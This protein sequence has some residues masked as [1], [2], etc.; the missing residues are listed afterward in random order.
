M[1]K[2]KYSPLVTLVM[3][4]IKEAI[5]EKKWHILKDFISTWEPVDIV[6]LFKELNP[7]D[8]FIIFLMLPTNLQSAV[9]AKFDAN[10]QEKVLKSLS[11]QQVRQILSEIKPDDRTELFEE[12]PPDMIRK[13]LNI[14]S[15]EDRKEV[16]QLLAYPKDSVGRLLTPDYVA[17]KPSWTISNTMEHIRKYGKDAETVNVVYVV[18]DMG[19]LLDDIPIRK[20]ILAEP[21][22]TVESIMDRSYVSIN[23]YADQEEAAKVMQKYDLI[24]L[25]VT[26]NEGQLL[27]IVTIDD[28]IDVLQEEQTEDFTKL[29]A[30]ATKPIKVDFITKLKEIPLHKLYRSRVTWLLALLLMDLITGGII[31]SFEETIAR[32]VVLVTF[33]PVLVDT[34]G[35]AGSQSATLVIRAMALG[36]IQMADWF[37]LLGRE[38]LVA[39]A[40]GITMGLG[41]SVMGIIRGRSFDVAAVV[42]IA[43][44]IN[45]IVGSLIGVLLPFIFTKLKKDPATASTPL[46][47]TLADIIGTGIYLG[48]A[49]MMLH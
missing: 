29:S 42:V 17:I 1:P 9:F 37:K 14:L 18:D 6:E 22:Q 45:V 16:L 10:T 8:I 19:K 2:F 5:N 43:M 40:L 38:L 21:N 3:P 49:Y 15:P 24:A 44:I 39:G 48:I 33:L 23:A 26:N 11:E 36:T 20:L 28:I 35:N 27:G 31:Q 32:Y 34:A 46:I 4:E 25:P 13:L 7:E 41:I 12:L 30:I 47:T